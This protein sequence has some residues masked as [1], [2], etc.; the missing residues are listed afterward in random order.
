MKTLDVQTL[1]NGIDDL[2]NKLKS[3]M[4]ELKELEHTI[5]DFTGLNDSF[6]GKGGTAVRNFYQDWHVPLL[7]YRFFALQNYERVLNNIKKA[8]TELESDSNGFIRQSFLE[9]ELSDGLNKINTTTAGLVDEANSSMASVNDIVYVPRLNDN[10][11]HTHVQQANREIDNSIEE[12]VKYDTNQTKELDTVEH[13]INLMKSYINEVQGMFE[14]GKLSIENYSIEQLQDKP[15]YS[16]LEKDLTTKENSWFAN[17]FL[18]PFDYINKKM[19]WGDNLLLAYQTMTT[20]SALLMARKLKVHYFGGK[21]TLWNLLKGNYEFSVKTHPSWTSK[22]KHNSKMAKR[23]L[24]FSRSKTPKNPIMRGTQ[25]IVRSYESPA[26]LYKNVAGYPKDISRMSGREFS[27]HVYSRM[28]TGTKD[29][30]GKA[31]SVRGFSAIGKSVPVLGLVVTGLAN[32]GE[33]TSA[34]N[35]GKSGWEKAGRASAGFATDMFAIGTGTRVGI[36]LGSFA[37][38]PG[39]IIGGAVGGLAGGLLSSTYG[40]GIK[41]LGEKVGE[42]FGETL[43]EIGEVAEDVGNKVKDFTSDVGEKAEDLTNDLK[44]SI[45]G[46]FN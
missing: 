6:K 40:D 29:V 11:F 10:Q 13:D 1:H 17:M 41:D 21:P 20:G 45:S 28:T 34:E 27:K 14:S 26:H 22:G 43:N 18:T 42:E 31:T 39:M 46:W 30:L 35:R 3:Q 12:L 19:S 25:H 23:L 36:L 32:A 7:S 8:T 15:S 24:D 33:F 4:T 5:E 37:G 2:L 16:K 9:G 44:E 38:P